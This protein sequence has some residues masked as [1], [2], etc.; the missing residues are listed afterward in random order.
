MRRVL[1]KSSSTAALLGQLERVQHTPSLSP[2]T[3]RS[4]HPSAGD[5]R[6]RAGFTTSNVRCTPAHQGSP[7]AVQLSPSWRLH[8][9]G[10]VRLLATSIRAGGRGA[11]GPKTVCMKPGS[12]SPLSLFGSE[13]EPNESSETR[14]SSVVPVRGARGTHLRTTTPPASG[15]L[16][17]GSPRVRHTATRQ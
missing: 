12:G 11:T 4:G 15:W 16:P 3:G 1:V 7:R 5:I 9:R 6:R 2:L 17:R 8:H 10:A 14:T 13:C